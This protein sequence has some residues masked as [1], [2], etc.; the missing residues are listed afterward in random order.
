MATKKTTTE[1][2]DEK[3]GNAKTGKRK[4]RPRAPKTERFPNPL[5]GR[6]P[7]NER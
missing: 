6:L 3:V 1:T 4:S 2:P 5:A 7:R